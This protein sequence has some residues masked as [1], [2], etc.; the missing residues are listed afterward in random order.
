M[1]KKVIFNMSKSADNHSSSVNTQFQSED[2]TLKFLPKMLALCTVQ[3]FLK[4]S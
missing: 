4:Q 2:R 1:S 3:Q